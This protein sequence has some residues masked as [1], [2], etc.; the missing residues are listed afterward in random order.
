MQIV[1]VLVQEDAEIIILA[2]LPHLKEKEAILSY[3]RQTY[4]KADLIKDKALLQ[5][6]RLTLAKLEDQPEKAG[7]IRQD[8]LN[9]LAEYFTKQAMAAQDAGQMADAM[10]LAIALAAVGRAGVGQDDDGRL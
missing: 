9:Q 6:I 7:Q 4:I 5:I 8:H 2:G 3:A 1:A 10:R